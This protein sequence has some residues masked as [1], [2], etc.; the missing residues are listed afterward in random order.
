MKET[1]LILFAVACVAAAISTVDS[2]WETFKTKFD[3]Q[4]SAEEDVKRRKIFYE[5]KIMIDEHNQ[6]YEEGKVTFK[7][8]INE[9][10]DM[11]QEETSYLRGYKQKD[12]HSSSSRASSVFKP[13]EFVIYPDSIDW[14]ERGYVTP[15]KYQGGCGSCWAF[16]AVGS[17]EGQNFAKTGNLKLTSLSEQNLVDCDKGDYGCDGGLII[18][19]FDY[20][21]NNHGIDTEE[22]YPYVAYD[23][24]CNFNTKNIG[25]YCSGYVNITSGSE[26]DLMAAVA[27]IGPV[28]VAIDADHTDFTYYVNGVY[29]NPLCSSKNLDHAVLVV[30]YGTYDNQDYWLIKNSWGADWGDDGYIMMARN[31]ENNCGIATAAAYPLV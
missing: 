14:R 22:S 18:D 24:D 21:I 20:V 16:S 5:N 23:Q 13:K 3:K 19:A 4:Y 10:A 9:F 15:V 8:G 17:L 26:Y 28:S 1:C 2:E 12:T 29:Y 27:T 11:L 7:M 31:R 6:K 25:G 30:G